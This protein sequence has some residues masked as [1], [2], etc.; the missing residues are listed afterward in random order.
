MCYICRADV[1]REGYGHFCQHFRPEGREGGGCK[2]CGRCDLYLEEEE[3]VVV[4]RARQ[5]AVAEWR[6]MN[7]GS[8][9]KGLEEVEKEVLGMRL[10]DLAGSGGVG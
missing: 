6:E 7:A 4:E 10:G 8:D 1:G 5:K 3:G 2:E 9:V